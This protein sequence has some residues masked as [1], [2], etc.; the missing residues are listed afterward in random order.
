MTIINF[1]IISTFLI[2]GLILL[3]VNEV[4]GLPVNVVPAK[5]VQSYINGEFD[6]IINYCVE[7]AG[8]KA[9]PIQDL[10]DKGLVAE[11]FND[12]SC[13][14]VK[15]SN[16]QMRLTP[17]YEWEEALE[18]G[19]GTYEKCFDNWNE[20]YAAELLRNGNR[21]IEQMCEEYK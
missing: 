17:I 5:V 11:H 7:H 13:K 21:T 16:D 15:D 18:S 3:V 20:P 1:T 9:N 4:R 14:S 8:D 2:I 19:Y 12:D 6:I 10:I